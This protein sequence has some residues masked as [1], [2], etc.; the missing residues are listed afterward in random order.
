MTGKKITA[1]LFFLI[2][3]IIPMV[4]FILP[5]EDFSQMEN[6]TLATFPKLNINALVQRQFM[7][8]FD[9][10]FSDHFVFR[11]QWISL[12]GNVEYAQGKRESNN[13]FICKD[14]YIQ[15][16]DTPDMSNIERTVEA[17][18]IFAETKGIVPYI[19]I[20]PSASEIQSDYLPPD[21]ASTTWDQQELITDI[22]RKLGANAVPIDV[23]KCLYAQKDENIFYKTDHHWTTEGAYYAYVEAGKS[24]DYQGLNRDLFN[25]ENVSNDF[26][27]TLYSRSAYRNIDP[28]IIQIYSND[29]INN[30][31]SYT[32]FDGKEEKRYDS[33]YFRE[34]LDA[35]DKYSLF[36][37]PNQPI[38]TITKKTLA[39]KSSIDPPIEKNILI[40]KDSYA[41]AFA[42]FL[43]EAYDK[44]TLVDMR[45]LNTSFEEY[46][47]LDDYSQV[48]FLYSMDTIVNTT[49]LTKINWEK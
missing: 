32:V 24:L 37:G 6:R 1:I 30:I 26:Y 17:L 36:L 48:L 5:K 9:S 2:V 12:K 14:R 13:I 21:A 20:V 35:K 31:E 19:M 29:L 46:I 3:L 4:T 27:G 39:Q 43:T 10:Y 34:Y 18:N 47:N 49:D 41:Q 25:I 11:D 42:P 15:R 33:I 22:N 7:K 40:F 45:Y 28:D 38:V 23:Y 8:G 16:L 44:I